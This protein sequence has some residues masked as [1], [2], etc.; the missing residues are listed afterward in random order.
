MTYEKPELIVVD[1]VSSLVLGEL[2][3]FGD[4]GDPDNQH[5]EAGIAVGL[6]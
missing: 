2:G 3:G 1:V 6:D 5:I 4:P